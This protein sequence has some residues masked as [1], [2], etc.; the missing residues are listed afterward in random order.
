MLYKTVWREC[1]E[2]L[3][4]VWF[5]RWNE[6]VQCGDESAE[7]NHNMTDFTYYVSSI[8]CTIKKYLLLQSLA[9][10]LCMLMQHN[11]GSVPLC[12]QYNLSSLWHG[13]YNQF[14]QDYVIAGINTKLSF[15]LKLPQICAG[16]GPRC[17]VWPH[18]NTHLD[19][20]IFYYHAS[21]MSTATVIRY[22]SSLV[23]F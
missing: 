7:P 23:R 18:H 12:S 20:M 2:V 19:T 3:S 14:S 4:D 1:W 11:T 22:V 16:F 13:L 21:N 15:F 6:S 9:T 5:C 8:Y 17:V 10:L